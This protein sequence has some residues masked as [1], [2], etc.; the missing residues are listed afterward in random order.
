M[1]VHGTND[2][3]LIK[4][5]DRLGAGK[6]V[7]VRGLV[8]ILSCAPAQRKFGAFLTISDIGLLH[9]CMGFRTSW[10]KMVFR[11]RGQNKM[12]RY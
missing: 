11:G 12:V 3:I 5:S 10:P 6:S 8:D 4:I 7:Q 9:I 2:N 1:R